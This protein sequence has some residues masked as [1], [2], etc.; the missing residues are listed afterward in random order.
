MPNH[1]LNARWTYTEQIVS[2]FHEV[3]ELYDGTMNEVHHFCFHT[4]ISSNECFTFQQAMKQVD[5]M[6]FVCSYTKRYQCPRGEKS[7]DDR[8]E[9][10]S[11]RDCQNHKIH[12]VF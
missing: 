9:I 7:L 8:P 2:C 11:P 5:I 6:L 3:N 1:T 12:L 10:F 4:D